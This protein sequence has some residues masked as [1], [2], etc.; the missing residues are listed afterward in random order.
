M[1]LTEERME[2]IKNEEEKY[3]SA[4]SLEQEEEE[5]YRCRIRKAALEY[6]MQRGTV[7]DDFDALAIIL[8]VEKAY[9]SGIQITPF[10]ESVYG[11]FCMNILTAMSHEFNKLPEEAK[12]GLGFGSGSGMATYFSALLKEMVEKSMTIMQIKKDFDSG[13]TNQEIVQRNNLKSIDDMF[14]L[15]RIDGPPE[16]EECIDRLNNSARMN[17]TRPKT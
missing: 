10:E 6:V 7:Y 13:M 16:L 11:K 1:N 2:E 12:Q 14:E 17:I 4:L 5:L 8:M 15:I 3:I 9:N